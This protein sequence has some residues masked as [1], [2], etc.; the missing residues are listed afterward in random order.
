VSRFVTDH[1]D[2]FNTT[3]PSRLNVFFGSCDTCMEHLQIN[4]IGLR[5]VSTPEGGGIAF[6]LWLGGSLGRATPTVA[7]RYPALIP[8][9]E[10]LPTVFAVAEL[11]ATC[12][13]RH[14]YQGR[15]KYTL[16]KLGADVFFDHLGQKISEVQETKD[17]SIYNLPHDQGAEPRQPEQNAIP[18]DDLPPGCEPQAEPGAFRVRGMITRGDLTS[19]QFRGLA[20]LVETCSE[21]WLQWTPQQNVEV[22]NVRREH[23][24]TVAE[25]LRALGIRPGA[26]RTLGDVLTCPGTEYCKLAITASPVAAATL[27]SHLPDEL[28]DDPL[29]RQVRIHISGCMNSCAQHQV[30]DIGLSGSMT[31]HR[32][33]KRFTYQLWLGAYLDA[34]PEASRVGRVCRRG[35]TD[36]QLVPLVVALLELYRDQRRPGEPFHAAVDR[37]GVDAFAEQLAGVCPLTPSDELVDV[38]ME[39]RPTQEPLTRDRLSLPVAEMTGLPIVS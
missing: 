11:H 23:L 4:D 5:A 33:T 6:E 22:P 32:Q 31:A 20:D 36:E 38:P 14:P 12:S 28:S 10:V 15:L 25:R 19:R 9:A 1:A 34:R 3:M 2:R 26:D 37:V 13:N 7:V 8:P 35:I 24:E 17:F 16:A 18:A 29:I 30:A 21:R 27:Q 39:A